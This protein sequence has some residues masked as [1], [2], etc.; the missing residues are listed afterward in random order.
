MPD[1]TQLFFRKEGVAQKSPLC[2]DAPL[3]IQ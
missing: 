2:A 1:G 3:Q